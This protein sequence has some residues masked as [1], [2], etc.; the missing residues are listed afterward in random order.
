MGPKFDEAKRTARE[1]ELGRFAQ[2]QGLSS[3]DPQS[4][5]DLLVESGRTARADYIAI[6]DKAHEAGLL[7]DGV[8]SHLATSL[9]YLLE[10]ADRSTPIFEVARSSPDDVCEQEVLDQWNDLEMLYGIDKTTSKGT[11]AADEAEPDIAKRSIRYAD[12]IKSGMVIF[13]ANDGATITWGAGATWPRPS[14]NA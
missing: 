6:F 3:E 9:R 5:L 8:S 14:L 12:R 2:E 7:S 13:E 10:I 11:L 1:L 4:L